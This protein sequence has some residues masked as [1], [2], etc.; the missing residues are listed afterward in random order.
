MFESKYDL[1]DYAERAIRTSQTI[2]SLDPQ[3]VLRDFPLPRNEVTQTV[4]REIPYFISRISPCRETKSLC[5]THV[6]RVSRGV[7]VQLQFCTDCNLRDLNAES[8][9]GGHSLHPS[10]Y[11]SL[12]RVHCQ[13][14]S[15]PP[16][17]L[18][19]VL[20]APAVRGWSRRAHL[21]RPRPSRRR[22]A[23]FPSLSLSIV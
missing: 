15:G 10:P 13:P 17:L 19:A 14:R 5:K 23:A 11:F 20:H 16:L 8:L 1:R 2:Y 6:P 3:T 9:G 21:P 7:S 18:T 4:L 12:I 22:A